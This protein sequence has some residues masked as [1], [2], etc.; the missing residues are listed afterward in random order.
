MSHVFDDSE[1]E[2]EDDYTESMK[3]INEIEMKINPK[4]EVNDKIKPG[5]ENE[6]EEKPQRIRNDAKTSSDNQLPITYKAKSRTVVLEQTT[7]NSAVRTRSSNRLKNISHGKITEANITYDSNGTIEVLMEEIA[8]DQEMQY[9]MADSVDN[10]FDDEFQSADSND[11]LTAMMVDDNDFDPE[12]F[13]LQDVTKSDEMYSSDDSSGEK[14]TE[15]EYG[16][17]NHRN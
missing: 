8:D 11:P 9:V 6:D 3:V 15:D 1:D 4:Q 7:S 12:P 5:S 17:F 16:K 10:E 13:A 2:F 14:Q